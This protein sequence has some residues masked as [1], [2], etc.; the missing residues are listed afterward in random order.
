MRL[1]GKVVSST[2]L[3]EAG[4]DDYISKPIE[5]EDVLKKYA[6]PDDSGVAG[7][8]ICFYFEL[9]YVVTFLAGFLPFSS[10]LPKNL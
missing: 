3:I 7:L 8:T 1:L 2:F 6:Y 4:C 9:Q 10:N 5:P